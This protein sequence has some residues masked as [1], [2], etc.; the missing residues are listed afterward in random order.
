MGVVGRGTSYTDRRDAGRR[1][2][3]AL[4]HLRAPEVTVL[5][6][7]RG[8]VPVAYEVAESLGAPLDV[9]VVRK[10]GVPRH[11]ELAMGAI[12]EGDVEVVDEPVVGLAHVT[13]AEFRAVLTQER[14]ELAQRVRRYRDAVPRLDLADR[15][16]VIVDDGMAT[17]S[18]ARAACAVARAHAPARV[19]LAVP[20]A[21]PEAVAALAGA[22]DEV[23]CPLRPG[24]FRAV[25]RWYEEFRQT[26]EDEVLSL[27]TRSRTH[28]RD[29]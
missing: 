1:L 2:A 22:A 16:A 20:V 8:G 26:S 19:V 3:S 21:S 4:A 18:T 15:I 13:E 23:V 28:H 10:L 7:P 29:T 9:I 24:D 17:G 25:G 14:D 27:L 5:G 6:L 12:G 11:S